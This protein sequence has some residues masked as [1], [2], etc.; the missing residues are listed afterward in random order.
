VY[1]LLRSTPAKLHL[2]LP[3]ATPSGFSIGT[4]LKTNRLRRSLASCV[5]PVKKSN[6]PRI[7]QDAGVSPGCTRALSITQCRP[8]A[9]PS[10]AVSDVATVHQHSGSCG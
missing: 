10:A 4:I 8:S 7:I 2:L 6:M 5:G 1:H 9:A 3:L